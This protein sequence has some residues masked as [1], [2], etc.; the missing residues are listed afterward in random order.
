VL[1]DASAGDASARSVF[2]RSYL[3]PIRNYLG[4]RWSNSSQSHAIDDAVQDV[5]VE[6]FKPNGALDGAEQTNGEFRGLLYAV[7]RNVAR[8]YEERAVRPGRPNGESVYLDDLPDRAEALSRIFDRSWAEAI[9]RDAILRHARVARRSDRDTR[10]RYRILR[11]RHQDGLA[12]R[13][14]AERLAEPDIEAVHNAYRRARREF[15]EHMR[16]ATAHHTGAGPDA[17]DAE[18]QRV[19]ALL[20]S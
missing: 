12:I 3:A 14:I 6:C 20:G 4:H 5:F 18:C 11:L 16:Q 8:R 17:L 1:R 7:V 10:L 15:R 2:A 13:E 19:K 9:V